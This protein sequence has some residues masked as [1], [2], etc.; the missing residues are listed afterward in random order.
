[1][2]KMQEHTIFLANAPN[3]M[4]YGEQFSKIFEINFHN[5]NK[6]YIIDYKDEI[7]CL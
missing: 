2:K 1:M 4:R 7:L 3:A 6:T 5:L